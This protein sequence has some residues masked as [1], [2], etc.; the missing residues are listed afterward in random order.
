MESWDLRQMFSPSIYVVHH[1]AAKKLLQE[2]GY[3]SGTIFW[4]IVD[5]V[6]SW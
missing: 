2:F 3:Q 4:N 5:L 1:L 6:G